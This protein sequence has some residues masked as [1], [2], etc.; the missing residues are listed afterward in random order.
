VSFAQQPILQVLD[1]FGTVRSTA[2][3]VSD[4]TVVTAARS[5]GSGTLQG[6]LTATATNGV[7]LR[8]S[9]A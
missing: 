6:T 9:L 2:N 8:Q 1:Q 7:A 4:S 3:G 5:A